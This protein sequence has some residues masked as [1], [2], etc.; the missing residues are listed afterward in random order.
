M[1]LGNGIMDTIHDID[2]SI[3]LSGKTEN[4]KEFRKFAFDCV[5]NS[6]LCESRARRFVLAID[7]AI[8]SIIW[9]KSTVLSHNMGI[10]VHIEINKVSFKALIRE[11][12][13]V[14][15]LNEPNSS[16]SIIQEAD[17]LRKCDLSIYTLC[18]IMD[19][20]DYEFKQG[21]I[22]ELRITKFL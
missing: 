16:T 19:E 2:K 12:E 21:F 3:N 13:N 22:N 20:V 14:F 10:E 4:L 6:G 9:S 7:E 15:A 11:S 17:K 8:T 1:N 18:S 5:E